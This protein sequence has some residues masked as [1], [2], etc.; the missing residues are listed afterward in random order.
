MNQDLQRRRGM[1]QPNIEHLSVGVLKTLR[2]L[3]AAYEYMPYHCFS[4]LRNEQ[5][6]DFVL[7]ELHAYLES[8]E[9]N[10]GYLARE[11]ADAVG[12]AVLRLLPWD[13]RIFKKEMAA[14]DYLMALGSYAEKVSVLSSLLSRVDNKCRDLK[15]EHLS[16]KVDT[17]DL[18]CIHALEKAGFRLMDTLVTYCF[19]FDKSALGARDYPYAIRE[20]AQEDT[21]PIVALARLSFQEYI[22]R[23]HLDPTLDNQDCDELYGEWARNSCL[24]VVA[25]RVSVVEDDAEILGFATSKLHRK[26]NRFTDRRI[27]EIVLV[28]VSPKVRGGGVYTSFIHEGLCFLHNR[29]DFVQVVTQINNTHVQRA[30]NNL[31]FRLI[32]SR[33]TFHKWFEEVR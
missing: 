30:W 19:D 17:A 10:Y 12:L 31:G 20:Q 25:D 4:G 5:L 21:E 28:C 7:E 29:V 8:P 24:G 33:S 27:G 26:V 15:I 6:S 32:G 22:D 13:K 18:S 1:L 23:F 11:G 9:S 2:P 16:I 14:V 3:M